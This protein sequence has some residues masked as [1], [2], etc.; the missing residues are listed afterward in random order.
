MKEQ[1]N[2]NTNIVV[3][4]LVKITGRSKTSFDL[5]P[6]YLVIGIDIFEGYLGK[7]QKTYQLLDFSLDIK[8]FHDNENNP[9]QN[10]VKVFKEKEC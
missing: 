10:V 6:I 3:G 5:L 2:V 1:E 4:D 9:Y 7:K 8:W